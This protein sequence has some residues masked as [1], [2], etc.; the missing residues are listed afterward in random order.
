MLDDLR[1]EAARLIAADPECRN[2]VAIMVVGGGEGNTSGEDLSA[3]ATTFLNVSG[4]RI[5]IHVIAIAPL[6]DGDR[7]RLEDVARRSGG[8]FTEITAADAST[9][10]PG[11]PIPKFVEAVNFA[12]SHTFTDQ[13]DFDL[14]PDA[15][16]PYGFSTRHQVTSPIVGSVDLEECGRHHW[17]DAAGHDITHPVTGV[18]IPQRSNL[19]ITTGFRL[20]GFS[21]SMEAVRVYR[22][23]AD[24]TKSVGYKFV[25]DGTKLWVASAPAAVS[26]NIYTAL[27]DGSMVA[28]N[29]AN[30]AT[31]RQY[32]RAS[33]TLAA[34]RIIDYVR[35]QPLGAFVGSTPAIM[36][37]PS[38]D[39]P[40]DADYPDSRTRTSERRS[41]IW[42]GRQ[43]RHAPRHRRAA[44]RRKCGRSSPSTCCRSSARC[45]SGQPIGDFR[46]LR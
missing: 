12:V 30:A 31:L 14:A 22:P 6:S 1:T 7:A 41:I 36:D 32:L 38:L 2:T 9:V 29:T 33:S 42:V 10:T 11:Q 20:P 26:R 4:R 13:G 25:S 18:E 19:M 34:E 45:E 17:H 21:G 27:P 24:S 39:P 43:R 16:H 3:K 44:R 40:P 37:P 35:A 8:R 5:P 28:F 23:V 46:L 15:T